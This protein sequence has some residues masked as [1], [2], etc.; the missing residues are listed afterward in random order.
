MGDD[1]LAFTR[2]DG[3]ACVL[4]LSNGPIELP[5]HDTVL[6]TSGPLDEGLLPP[7]TAAW[8]SAAR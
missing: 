8:L 5:A 2:G 4:N 1:V 7:D 6:L 3:F